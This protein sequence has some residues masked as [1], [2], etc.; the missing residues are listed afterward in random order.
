MNRFQ[1]WALE[2]RPEDAARGA[3]F[4]FAFFL[5]LAV[6]CW[7]N[8]SHLG[9][10]GAGRF[11]VSHFPFLD[12]LLPA[13]E[14]EW[15]LVLVLLQVFL[16]MRAAFGVALQWTVPLLCASYSATYFWSQLDSYQHHYMVAVLLFV[17]S[18][19][20]VWDK[21]ALKGWVLRGLGL[22]VSIV[23]F[24]AAVAKMDPLWLD[25]TTI[26]TQITPTW[27]RAWFE[28]HWAALAWVVLLTELFL[29]IAWQ[30]RKLWPLALGI[31]V[32]MHISIELLEFKIGAFSYLM[33]ATYTLLWPPRA[34]TWFAERFRGTSKAAPRWA[35]AAVAI[36]VGLSFYA[37]PFQQAGSVAAL[38]IAGLASTGLTTVR[39]VVAHAAMPLLLWTTHGQSDIARDYYRYIGGD[40][41]RRGLV[42][43][44]LA[45]YTQVTVID[46]DYFS[47][48]VRRGDLLMKSG[49]PEEALAEYRIA[50]TLDPASDDLTV[51]IRDAEA[52]ASGAR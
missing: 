26:S 15:M 19:G 25:G 10:Y 39:Q 29:A 2:E 3:V 20:A 28:G 14:K 38:I 51:R 37:L 40:T 31:G 6:D 16:C 18:V 7:E 52:A 41:R 12:G 42:D 13:P 35:V 45:A 44:A 23:Y 33:L 5:V 21:G 36:G 30:V 34:V 24:W 8:V 11:N 4:R 9:R 27:A 17:A 50:Q 1:T 49:R 47:G 22:M 43:E 32:V 46:P 48:H